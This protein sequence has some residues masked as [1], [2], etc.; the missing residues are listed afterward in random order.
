MTISFISLVFIWLLPL[1]ESS[2]V[3]SGQSHNFTDVTTGEAT[4]N[5]FTQGHLT[6]QEA[7][8]LNPLSQVS[9]HN[10]APSITAGVIPTTKPST[11]PL[12]HTIQMTPPKTLSP[13]NESTATNSIMSQLNRSTAEETP[14]TSATKAENS[15]ASNLTT[16]ARVPP[17]LSSSTQSQA[18]PSTFQLTSD[19][20]TH[21]ST[22][23]AQSTP[24]PSTATTSTKPAAKSTSPGPVTGGDATLATT[25]TPLV[26]ITSAKKTLNSSKEEAKSN[27]GE[28]QGKVVAGIIGT[29]LVLMMVGFLVIF[30]KKRK[31]QKQ[32]ITTADWAGPSPFLQSGADNGNVALR[33]SNQISLSSFLP[34][35]LSKRLSLLQETDEELEDM[36]PST[37]FGDKGQGNTSGGQVNGK[38]APEMNGTAAVVTEMK[39]EGDVPE[40]V[41]NSVLLST[42]NNSEAANLSQESENPPSP[43][44][45]V[46]NDPAQ[47]NDGLGQP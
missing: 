9:G 27:K 1:A 44:A 16:T 11:K 24:L 34:Q 18:K 30:I 40:T 28:K 37:T 42:N 15:S 45:A 12:L 17:I 35:R 39:S 20:M 4:G 26:H 29:A 47:L 8:S 41:E 32:Q 19:E 13:L 46:E 7:S 3:T 33:S 38:D 22:H 23:P 25:K 10:T 5:E 6:T 31:L 21:P 2:A 14:T 43:P 36:T